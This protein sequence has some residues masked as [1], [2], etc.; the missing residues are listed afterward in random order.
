[1]NITM[2][3]EELGFRDFEGTV[4]DIFRDQ[5]VRVGDYFAVCPQNYDRNFSCFS[6][7]SI[8]RLVDGVPDYKFVF[9]VT[10]V[11]ISKTPNHTVNGETYRI[12]DEKMMS[13]GISCHCS[14]QT[15]I[16]AF[17]RI[18]RKEFLIPETT[19][20]DYS[21][22]GKLVLE[23]E[24][25]EKI[26][27]VLKQ[28]KNTK[29]IFEEWGLGEVIEYGRGMTMLF[30]GNPGTGKTFAARKIAE[31]LKKKL[32]IADTA[33]LQSAIPGEMERNLQKKFAEAKN[34]VLLLDECDSLTMSRDN[35]GMILGAEINCLLTEI[36]KFE[37]VC[38]LTT[39]RVADLDKAL[40]RRISLIIEFP[41]PSVEMRQEIWKGLL[42]AKMPLAKDVNIK[43]LAEFELTG[44]LI[45]NVVL[46]AARL[47]VSEERKNVCMMNF[48]KAI[49]MTSGGIK[50]F[51]G[52]SNNLASRI[53]VGGDV[54]EG[55]KVVRT[56]KITQA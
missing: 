37:G 8:N 54:Q 39:N 7:D 17:I 26:L 22:F 24:A 29:K 1:M 38:I 41:D 18:Y 2:Q 25:R 55:R 10:A 16:P 9:K 19:D 40:E 44:G 48:V 21:V 4:F 23:T 50:A 32:I 11:D 34:K 15:D 27:A 47:A 42:P 13:N 53:M 35:V 14:D 46:N 30:W 45:K 12:E 52:K 20:Y 51:K 36:E 6:I 3:G 33:A 49:E 56:R 5:E 28:Q 43:K 31:M